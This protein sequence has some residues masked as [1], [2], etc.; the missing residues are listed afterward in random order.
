MVQTLGLGAAGD[1]E[2]DWDGDHPSVHSAEDD[3]EE[4]IIAG[5]EGQHPVA[6][7]AGKM[8]GNDCDLV[9]QL[10]VGVAADCDGTT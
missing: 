5:D 1:G 4:T 10:T 9:P 3:D 6:G 8:G 2:G 7:R